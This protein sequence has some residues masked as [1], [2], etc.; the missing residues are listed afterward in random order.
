MVTFSMTMLLA[1][2]FSHFLKDPRGEKKREK[3][4]VTLGLIYFVI[5]SFFGIVKIEWI[6]KKKACLIKTSYADSFSFFSSLFF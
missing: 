3:K 1:F 2:S 5:P 6:T 4:V